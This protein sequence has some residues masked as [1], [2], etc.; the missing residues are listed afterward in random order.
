MVFVPAIAM[1]AVTRIMSAGNVRLIGDEIQEQFE[2]GGNLPFGSA[3]GMTL[4]GLFLIT[5][6][7]GARKGSVQ[8]GL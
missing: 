3:L 7:I 5:Y 6:W 4:L 2:G 8:R 1:F